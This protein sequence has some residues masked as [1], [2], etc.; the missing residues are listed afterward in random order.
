M[1]AGEENGSVMGKGMKVKKGKGSYF[2][3]LSHLRFPV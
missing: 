1:E 2:D 3:Y